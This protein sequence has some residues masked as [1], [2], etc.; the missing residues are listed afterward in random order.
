MLHKFKDICDVNLHLLHKLNLKLDVVLYV[1]SLTML[2]TTLE[3]VVQVVIPRQ[4]IL[5]LALLHYS[6]LIA[7]VEVVGAEVIKCNQQV[8]SLQVTAE[9]F[10]EFLL[11][12]IVGDIHY[13]ADWEFVL[14][15]LHNLLVTH[16]VLALVV[17]ITLVV[18]IKRAHEHKTCRIPVSK[19][20][21]ALFR[22]LI[23]IAEAYDIT[24]ILH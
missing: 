11:L 24:T 18:V 4:I 3:F 10:D 14:Q 1:G 16:H 19:Q 13:L 5:T 17:V 23:E 20:C 22:C 7:L 9:Q 8:M 21:E 15:C 12:L 6:H 2:L